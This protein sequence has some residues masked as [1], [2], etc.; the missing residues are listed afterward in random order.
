MSPRP[1]AAALFPP[2]VFYE[3]VDVGDDLARFEEIA[4]PV[5]LARAVQK[6][7]LE[8]AA[9]RHCAR[10]AL[11]RLDPLFRLAPILIGSH[12]APVWPAGAIGAITHSAGFA[13]AAVAR[14]TDALGIGLDTERVLTAPALDEVADEV[15]TPDELRALGATGAQRA[16]LLTTVFSAKESIFKCLFPRVGHYFDFHDVALVE[17]DDPHQRFTAQLQ[18]ALAGLARGTLL[19]G[20]FVH[21]AGLVHTAIV[22]PTVAGQL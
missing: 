11:G 15:A 6:R 5:E 21:A 7:K 3:S 12:R 19:E 16:R 13:A 4:L 18:V 14:A 2:F 9:G 22:L 20:R 17:I 10:L 8:F 1:E